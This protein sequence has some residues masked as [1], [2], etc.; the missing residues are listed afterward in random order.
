MRGNN[1]LGKR[2]RS[3]NQIEM[4]RLFPRFREAKVQGSSSNS[5][6]THLAYHLPSFAKGN[7]NI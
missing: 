6:T 3:R 1:Y 7:L 4:P 5:Y 2:L